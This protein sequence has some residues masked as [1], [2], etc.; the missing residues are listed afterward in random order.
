MII[1]WKMS[2]SVGSNVV[3]ECLQHSSKCSQTFTNFLTLCSTK[4]TKSCRFGTT[5]ESKLQFSFFW[6]TIPLSNDSHSYLNSYITVNDTQ[7]KRKSVLCKYHV[8][9]IWLRKNLNDRDVVMMDLWHT[10]LY[11][12]LL[13]GHLFKNYADTEEN[14]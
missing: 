5:K 3:L 8:I 6:R 12:P 10:V 9:K 4:E 2:V 7:R 13:E 14:S 11:W 1:F